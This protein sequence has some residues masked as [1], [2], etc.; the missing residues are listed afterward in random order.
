MIPRDFECRS[1]VGKILLVVMAGEYRTQ[2]RD[3]PSTKAVMGRDNRY[4]RHL[5]IILYEDTVYLLRIQLECSQQRGGNYYRTNCTLPHD[6]NVWIDLNDDNVF[7]DTENASPYRW[8]LTSY[9][10]EG[11][12][13]LQLYIP[14]IDGREVRSGPHR[15]RM[16]VSLDEQYRRKCGNNFFTETREYNV[17]IVRYNTRPG[18]YLVL[19]IIFDI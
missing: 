2:I 13:D 3:D 14:I 15:M 18:K 17:T 10:P 16:A 7:S 12:Y 8:P 6:V 9:I 19:Y 4:E 5:T 1:D 11:I